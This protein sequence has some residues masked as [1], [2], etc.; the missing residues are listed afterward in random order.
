MRLVAVALQGAPC[1]P[2]Q[3][4][5]QACNQEEIGLPSP[6]HMHLT[7]QQ[8]GRG[9]AQAHGHADVGHH[10][11][12]LRPLKMVLH[13][14]AGHH[15]A[16]GAARPLQA[17]RRHQNAH[18]GRPGG[19]HRAQPGDEQPHQQDLL[20]AQAIAPGAIQELKAAVGQHKATE[21]ELNPAPGLRKG[22]VPLG[23]GRQAD[24]HGQQAK[25]GLR[26]DA[27][28]QGHRGCGLGSRWRARGAQRSGSAAITR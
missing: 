25:S 5:G 3:D 7:T 18:V 23:H 19:E 26:Q 20:S 15:Q 27:G 2:R 24:G 11:G 17:A 28:H 13:H 1:Q 16:G 21:G 22:R 10:A 9:R 6:G 4:H 14:G 8:C 12:A